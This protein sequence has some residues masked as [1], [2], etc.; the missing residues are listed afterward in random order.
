MFHICQDEINAVAQA[1]PWVT[2]A[3]LKCRQVIKRYLESKR[4]RRTAR[5]ESD[6]T[7][8]G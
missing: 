5:L 2:V 3:C 8:K 6:A 7:R 1:L 4:S